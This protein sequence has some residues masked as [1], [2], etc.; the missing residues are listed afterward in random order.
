MNVLHVHSG[1]MFGGVERMLQTLAPATAGTAPLRSSFALCFEGPVAGA[2]RAAAGEVHPLG[3]VRVRRI[4]EISRARRALKGLLA[5]QPWSAAFVH[6][7]WSQAIFGPTIL[8]SGTP[9]VRWLHAPEPGPRWLE[10]WAARSQPSL[11]LCNSRY[12]C[13]A[14]GT[15]MGGG[16]IA[17]QYPPAGLHRPA[18]GAR[19]AVRS[20]LGTPYDATAIVIAARMERWK[21][22]D[23]L[24]E[25]LATLPEN[26]WE[27]WIVGG[28]QRPAE[29]AY[30]DSLVTRAGELGLAS[31][32]RFLGQRDDVP[33]LLEGADLYCQPNRSAEPFGLSFVEA[34][35]AGLP[36]ITADLG[37]A[38]EIVDDSC[39]ILVE[40]GSVR[41]LTAALKRLIKDGGERGKMS[42]GARRR[43]RE[44]CDLPRSLDRLAAELARTL[45][46][47]PALT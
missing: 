34:L 11:V 45:T 1:N 21:G 28:P 26:G 29:Q 23:L 25:S 30:Y 2:L 37:A 4:D 38:P 13:R 15:R 12:T 14:A 8:K 27:A 20:E 9:L 17:V 24:L 43:A 18:P 33:R 31:R 32:V 44:F 3:V 16:P 35:G 40:A 10:G 36:V 5:S 22:H 46:T 41:A 42:D 47:T 19:G 6:S 7:A 39:G